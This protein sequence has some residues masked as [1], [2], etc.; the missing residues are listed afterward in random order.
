MK[1]KALG[2]VWK[3]ITVVFLTGSM[4]VLLRTSSPWGVIL[5]SESALL[6]SVAVQTSL[7]KTAQKKETLIY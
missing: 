1:Y 5:I 3:T 2:I 6:P 4:D 7:I